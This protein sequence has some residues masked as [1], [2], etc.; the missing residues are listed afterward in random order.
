MTGFPR[1]ALSAATNS[2][3]LR[4]CWG[5]SVA[6]LPMSPT[7]W[8]SLPATG[9][10]S[11]AG[12]QGFGV[13]QTGI[14]AVE[15]FQAM[16]ILDRMH[17]LPQSAAPGA[18]RVSGKAETAVIGDVIGE[19]LGRGPAGGQGFQ[20]EGDHVA[21]PRGHLHSHEDRKIQ[22]FQAGRP[23]YFQAA[24]V[25]DAQSVQ[26]DAAGLGHGLLQAHAAAA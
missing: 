17:M 16:Q 3:M 15:H 22:G 14:G 23:G 9:M 18:E 24:V 10:S 13:V 5:N 20:A 21:L 19:F 1:P 8:A 11:T 4:I 7:A 25:G 26:A 6:K 12:I 2:S